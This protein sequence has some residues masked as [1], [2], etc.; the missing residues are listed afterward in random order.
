LR[1]YDIIKMMLLLKM[2]SS[3]AKNYFCQWHH[4]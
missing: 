2:T 1:R 3:L 4:I